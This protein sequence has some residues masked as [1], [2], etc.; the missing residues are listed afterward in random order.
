MITFR[1]SGNL[2]DIVWSLPTI[3]DILR[4]HN[5]DKAGLY[6]L[7][8]VPAVYVAGPHPLGNIRLDENYARQLLPLLL[9]QDYIGDAGVWN[10]QPV[11]YDLDDFRESGF[12]FSAGNIGRYYCHAFMVTPNLS[13]PWLNVEPSPDTDG[14]IVIN[15]T[16]RARNRRLNYGFLRGRNDLVFVGLEREYQNFSMMVPGVPRWQAPDFLTLARWIKGAKA[17]IGNQSF[18]YAVAEALKVPRCLEVAD[19]S[20]NNIPSGPNAYEAFSQPLLM[21]IVKEL[22]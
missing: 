22:S 5:Q 2:G 13:D 14:K 8:G 6:M 20:P 9:A 19:I 15:R 4:R 10:G 21:R 11:N 1:H 3:K 12:N 18:P 7:T 17:F 16:E